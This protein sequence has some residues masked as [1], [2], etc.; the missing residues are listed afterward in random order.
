MINWAQT[1]LRWASLGMGNTLGKSGCYVVSLSMILGKTPDNILHILNAND[2]FNNGALLNDKAARVLGLK[3]KWLPPD[4]S[5][6]SYPIIGETDHWAHEG[7]PQHFFVCLDHNFIV[8][9]LNGETK[10]NPY[11]IVSYRKFS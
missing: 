3:Y 7:F 1:D 2:C 10:T 5:V 4:S 6:V 11:N 9:P 8:D